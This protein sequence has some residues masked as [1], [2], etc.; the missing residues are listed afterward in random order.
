[1]K[2]R[3][4]IVAAVV[5][6]ILSGILYW[7]EH[8]KP[9]EDTAKISADTPPVI[10]KLDELAITKLNLKRKDVEPLVLAKGDS[11]KWQITEPKLLGADQSTVSGIV[12]TLASLN[13][14]RLVE[15]KAAELKQYGLDQ[16]GLELDITEKN[17]KMQKLLIG[18]DTPASGAVYAMLAG[19]SRVFTMSKYMKTSVDKSL[20]DVRDKRLLTVN[21]EKISRIELINKSTN[22]EIEFGRNK[23]EWQIVKPKPLRADSV[24]V[25]E[26]SRSD[27]YVAEEMFVCG[28]A[29]EVSAVNSVDDRA[30]TCPGP[31]TKVIAE[32]FGRAVRGQTDKY[33][34]W[35]EHVDE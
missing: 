6:L 13:S 35:C 12:S 21:T 11:G 24:Q 25:G 20:N 27:L 1:M 17:N 34:N 10:L 28:T 15:D 29:A 8:R 18:D 30:I 2:I 14:E 26:L 9:A 16:P 19:D 4:L 32:E 33:K 31:M 5:F 3:G 7:S 22:Q 23:D